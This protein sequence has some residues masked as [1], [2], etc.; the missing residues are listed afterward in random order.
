MRAS[1]SVSPQLELEEA[2]AA[3]TDT[4]AS[5]PSEGQQ[6]PTAVAADQ[7]AKAQSRPHTAYIHAHGS[8]E[9]QG[10]PWKELRRM[11]PDPARGL[12]PKPLDGAFPQQPLHVCF[13]DICMSCLAG[14]PQ[15]SP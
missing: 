8:T 5:P 4:E 1:V 13:S 10:K 2:A 9:L 14:H 12:A 3:S 7:G 15:R 6:L 11:M